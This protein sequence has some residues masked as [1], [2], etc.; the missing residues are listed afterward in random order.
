MNNSKIPIYISL[1]SIYKNQNLLLQTLQSILKQ[2][3]MPNKIFLYLSEE[4]HIFDTG[5]KDRKITN[6][7]LLNFIDNNSIIEV[8]WV[9][10]TGSYRKLLP[11]LKDKWNKDCIIITIDDDTIYYENLIKNLVDDYN[12][13]NCVISYR[14]FTPLFNKFENF[15]YEIRGNQKSNSLYNFATGRGGIL[16]KPDFFKKTNDLIFNDEIYKNTCDKQD[17]IWFYLLRILN[18]VNCYL[19]FKKWQTRDIV[20]HG[21]YYHWN[22]KNNNNTKAFKN[23]YEKLMELDY[24]F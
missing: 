7:N 19:A 6:L 4:P 22:K 23:T 20:N 12:K 15:D 24:K 18:N 2:T 17:D 5:F 11:L 10:N 14:G 1:T 3:C 16:Y 9:K 8:K 21:L 13:Y